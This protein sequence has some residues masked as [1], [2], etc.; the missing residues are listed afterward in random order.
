VKLQSPSP[1]FIDSY[2]AAYPP[3]RVH[4]AVPSNKTDKLA[5]L[6]VLV[7]NRMAIRRRGRSTAP[8]L[9]KNT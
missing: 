4:R 7:M 9:E 6:A 2:V 8:A 1:N 5:H 3:G